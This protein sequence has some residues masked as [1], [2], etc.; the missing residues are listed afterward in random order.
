MPPKSFMT[1]KK[2]TVNTTIVLKEIDPSQL[3]KDYNIPEKIEKIESSI[4]D[5][6]SFLPKKIRNRKLKEASSNTNDDTNKTDNKTDVK[7]EKPK[8][9]KVK[10]EKTKSDKSKVEKSDFEKLS[11][12]LENVGLVKEQKKFEPT[13]SK[14]GDPATKNGP[15][16]CLN[17][18]KQTLSNET[19]IDLNCWWCRNTIPSDFQIIGCPLKYTNESFICEGC[20][21]SFNC[22]KAYIE[23][24]NHFNI[25]Y[26]ESIGLLTLLYS[27]TF[28]QDI[29]YSTIYPAPH[30]SLLKEYGGNLTIEQFRNEFQRVKYYG[31]S[32]SLIRDISKCTKTAFTFTE[33]T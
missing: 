21:C 22:V 6:N 20:F 28:N 19:N 15:K 5:N 29:L 32:G 10:S 14:I 30:W 7:I 8:S 27:K 1:A 26:R 31:P 18:N 33:R 23:D 17:F 4:N 11:H 2:K 24:I 16:M 13:I 25:K 3:I 12:Q 9:E